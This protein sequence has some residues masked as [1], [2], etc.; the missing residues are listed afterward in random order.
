MRSTIDKAGR[1]VI[2]RP[3]RK[4]LGWLGGEEIEID[5]VD[6]TVS[7]SPVTMKM[8]LVETDEGV[9]AVPESELPPLTEDVVRKT[10]DSVRR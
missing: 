3:L 2:P 1:V 10:R 9:V 5:V 7:I 8:T 4:E 6:G